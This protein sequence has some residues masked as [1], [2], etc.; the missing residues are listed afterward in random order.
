MGGLK[1]ESGNICRAADE[2][3]CCP[4]TVGRSSD[5]RARSPASIAVSTSL[6]ERRWERVTQTGKPPL[7]RWQGLLF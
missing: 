6:A 2:V 4:A 5:R 7:S 1:G 3:R